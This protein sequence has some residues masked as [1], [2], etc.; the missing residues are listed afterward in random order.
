MPGYKRK[1]GYKKPKHY[2]KPK[3]LGRLGLAKLQSRPRK[4]FSESRAVG[5]HNVTTD[6]VGIFAVTAPPNSVNASNHRVSYG[7]VEDMKGILTST[8]GLSVLGDEDD[9]TGLAWHIF[10][11]NVRLLMRNVEKDPCI[12]KIFLLSNLEILQ[13]E[14]TTD[15]TLNLPI[16]LMFRDLVAGWDKFT[17]AANFTHDGA[18]STFIPVA[19]G[20]GAGGYNVGS[21]NV[22]VIGGG[23]ASTSGTTDLTVASQFLTLKNSIGFLKKWKIVKYA[24]RKLQPGDEWQLDFKVPARTYDADKYQANTGASETEFVDYN[25][26]GFPNSILAFPGHVRIPLV[27]VRGMTGYAAS[28][29]NI[30]NWGDTNIALQNIVSASA[31]K[32][33]TTGYTNV[34]HIE[35]DALTAEA[36]LRFPSDFSA[37]AGN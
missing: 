11:Y 22:D 36:D 18:A 25:Q 6:S 1:R 20:G 35:K 16:E 15:V 13:A 29:H 27:F 9:K 3:A 10:K 19:P 17:A 30:Y 24:T 32:V 8:G 23:G 34:M 26:T 33:I 2:K 14:T 28:D 12:V 7:D 21:E 5:F 37:A 4:Y 31:L